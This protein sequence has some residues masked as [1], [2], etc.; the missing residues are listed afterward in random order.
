MSLNRPPSYLDI[1]SSF[2]NPFRAQT[3]PSNL[4][5]STRKTPCCSSRVH[6]SSW[7]KLRHTFR[8]KVSPSKQCLQFLQRITIPPRNTPT[9]VHLLLCLHRYE[10]CSSATE[11]TIPGLHHHNFTSGT[12]TTHNPYLWL[13][14]LICEAR[15]V[16]LAKCCHRTFSP[17]A[18]NTSDDSNYNL[19]DIL[20]Q[21]QNRM[22]VSFASLQ[23]D[24]TTLQSHITILTLINKTQSKEI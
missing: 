1:H 18:P 16:W 21:L 6:N 12:T 3:P 10:I 17:T 14:I 5:A 15:S 20:A 24:I 13:I 8:R 11:P 9:L 7:S 2:T 22:R 4:I 19:K 23:Q